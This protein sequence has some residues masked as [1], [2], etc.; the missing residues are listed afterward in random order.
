MLEERRKILTRTVPL[1][2]AGLLA[3][4]L[5]LYFV[6]FSNVIE[7]F[8]RVN[9]SIFSVAVLAILFE[10]TLFTFTWHYLL[11]ALSVKIKFLRALSYVLIGVFVDILIPAE[12]VSGE[13]SKVYLMNKDGKDVGK[14][15]ATLII[16]RI[17][18]MII[19]VVTLAVACVGLFAINYPLPNPVVY[20]IWIATAITFVFLVLIFIFCFNQKLTKKLMNKILGFVKRIIPKRFDLKK[21][22]RIIE[23][24][25]DT[26]HS[27]FS[28]LLKSPK[29][30]LISM[31]SAVL[32][33]I[34]C[35]IVSQL[36][37]FS[38]GYK[39]SF[40]VVV[41]VYS[42]SI[43]VQSV[44]AGIPAEVGL[45]EIVMSSLYAMF[46]VP[47]GISAVATILIR[48]LTVWLKFILGFVA[49]QW[50]GI[51]TITESPIVETDKTS[52][53]QI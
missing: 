32:S 12:S 50:T 45:T 39:I 15:T 52:F 10:V 51:K 47:L 22:E 37:F 2:L 20:L 23:K 7:A 38:L 44:P 49:L 43:I 6:G 28:Y 26:F 29:K 31:S 33:W 53:K 48:F 35:L 13:I 40:M 1:L 27:S 19:H 17:Y 24:G 36:V 11:R 46:G 30:L 41:A 42:L 16:Q 3:F 34:F 9:P 14:V 18:G 5:Y 25:L 4:I 21:W 8:A